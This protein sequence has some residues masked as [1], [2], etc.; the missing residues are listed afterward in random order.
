[1]KPAPA[2]KVKTYVA[3]V[4][5]ICAIGTVIWAFVSSPGPAKGQPGSVA[6]AGNRGALAP[7]ESLDPRLHL[8]LLAS[9]E[10]MKYSG[11]GKN[12]FR[13]E[14]EQIVIP[15]PLVNPLLG[16][17]QGPGGFPQAPPRPVVAP[18]PPSNL[19]FFGLASGKGEKPKAFVS[20][21][22]D[23]WICKEGDVVN[24]HYKIVRISPRE[25]EVEDLLNNHRESIP[26]T[27]S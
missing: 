24:R 17:Q 13:A 27:Q 15:K 20:H 25:L 21:G 18:P 22:D 8:D 9:A 12:I 26:I 2:S 7:A 1:M 11:K 19:K 16:Q 3:I 5:V 10:E 4:L 14:A 23:V 6:V